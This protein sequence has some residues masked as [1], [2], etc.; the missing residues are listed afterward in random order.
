M[1]TTTRRGGGGISD[2][3]QLET[4]VMT[5]PLTNPV[6]TIRMSRSV[7]PNRI[8]AVQSCH[9]TKKQGTL[10]TGPSSIPTM[11]NVSTEESANRNAALL[12][13]IW[14]EASCMNAISSHILE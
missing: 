12:I 9:Q 6:L 7:V 3:S 8:W 4:A 11:E 13:L 1:V 5:I 2:G 14:C 10:M